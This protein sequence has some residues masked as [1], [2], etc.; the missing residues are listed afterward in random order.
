MLM[1]IFDT[2]GGLCNQFYDIIN[3]VNFCL[4][5]NIF[6]TFR[7]CSFRNK[8]LTSWTNQ[9]FQNLFDVKMFDKYKLYIDYDKIKNDVTTDTCF[10]LTGDVTSSQMLNIKDDILNQLIKLNKKYV[11]LSSF[12]CLYN[13]RNIIDNTIPTNILASKHLITIYNEI[14]TKLINKEPYNFIHYRYE[15]DFTSHFKIKVNSLDKLITNLKF[16]NNGLKIYIATSDITNILNVKEYKNLLYKD[17]SVL[18]HLNFEQLAF[19]DYMF[20]LNSTECYGHSNSSFSTM[21]N[22][23][24]QTNNYYDKIIF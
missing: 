21:I 9:P 3:G 16:K 22:N 2:K 23:N 14:K 5:Y 18:S 19:I 13:F 8:D 1:L 17:E 10:N 15:K 6:F 20:G 24:K 7:Y 12:W 11:V 4:K